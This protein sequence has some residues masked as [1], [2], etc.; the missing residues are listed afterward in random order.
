[1]NV[2]V[3]SDRRRRPFTLTESAAIWNYITSKGLEDQVYHRSVWQNMERE[4]ITTHSA[5]SMRSHFR[6]VLCAKLKR[7]PSSQPVQRLFRRR[8]HEYTEGEDKAV[9]DY[10]LNN[11]FH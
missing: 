9:L 5:E 3:C 7:K 10:I 4:H 8:R 1:M 11:K 6:Q 2:S